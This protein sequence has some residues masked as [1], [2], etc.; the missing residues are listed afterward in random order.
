MIGRRADNAQSF[1]EAWAG[2][3]PRNGEIAELV[4]I[5]EI[6]CEAAIAEPTPQ[7]RESL[8]TALMTEA[9]TALVPVVKT[10]RPISVVSAPTTHPVRRRLAAVT[11][12]ILASAG[13]IGIVSS[14]ASA[15][16]GDMLYPVK[17]GVESVELAL[18]RDDASRGSFSLSQ[19]SERLAEA[20]TLSATPSSRT[21]ALVESTLGDFSSQATTGSTDLFRDFTRSGSEKS[22]RK[23]NDFAAAATAQLGTLSGALPGS[24][25]ESFMSA[26][27]TVTAIATQASMLCSSCASA[28]I[29]SLVNAV[30]ALTKNAD[31]TKTSST[32]KKSTTGSTEPTTKSPT[33]VAPIVKATVPTQAPAPI[34][35]VT[36]PLVGA[37]LGDAHQQ[38]VVPGLINGLPGPK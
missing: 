6:L 22:I 29:Q 31:T 12:A 23:V 3:A 4:R 11:T 8:R 33:P 10:G 37:L 36:D 5:A 9:E 38:G 14:S 35:A 32:T 13:L 7:F 28:D 15:V 19:A 2:R 16:P 34:G 17:R 18:H 27:R 21:D 1:D 20:R 24:A 26:A 25:N 30:T